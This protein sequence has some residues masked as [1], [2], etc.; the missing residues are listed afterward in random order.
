MLLGQRVE[1]IYGGCL[2]EGEGD[3][4]A[5]RAQGHIQSASEL[6]MRAGALQSNQRSISMQ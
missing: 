6:G 4:D 1:S 5:N 3:G 2:H